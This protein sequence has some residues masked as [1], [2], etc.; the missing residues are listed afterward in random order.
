MS[1]YRAIKT[2]VD[3]I[4]FDSKAE[5][6][7]YGELIMLERAGR[8]SGLT[9]QVSYELAKGVKF[10]GEKRAKPP[11]RYIADFVYCDIDAGGVI[12]CE[13]V[14]GVQTPLFRAKRHWMLAVHGVQVRVTS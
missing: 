5:A 8:I 6:R 13:D 4:T 9:R 7:R 14:K 12:V 2:V 10:E 3:G 1:K 11:L